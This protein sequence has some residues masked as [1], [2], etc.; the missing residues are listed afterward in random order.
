MS[1]L[2]A[3]PGFSFAEPYAFGVVFVGLAV[4][5]AVAALS[6]QHERAFSA[7]LIYLALGALGA[8]LLSVAG[9][10]WLHPVDNPL[11]LERLTEFAVVF[12]LFG[13]GLSLD[14]RLS[15]REWQTP[16]RLLLVAMPLTIVAV[17]LF[18]TQ[19]MGLSLAAAVLL[20][21]A[22]APTDPVLAG[23]VG[24][25]PP[26]E[27]EEFEP[28]FSLTSEAGLNDGL[29][30]PF[31]LFGV[32]LAKDQANSRWLEWLAAD[33]FYALIGGVLIGWII[34]RAAA[35]SVQGLRDRELLSPGLDGY[36]AIAI[37]LIIYGLGEVAGVYGFLAVFVGGLAFRRYER[38]HEM[39]A[40]VHLGAEQAEKL[41]ELTCVLMLGSMLTL[42]G[43][44]VPGWKGWLLAVVLIVA[45]RP[46][47][48]LVALIGSKLERP[49]ER[50]FVSWFGVRGIGT[51]YYVAFMVAAG[52]LEPGEQRVVAWTAVACV[53]L[54]I[55]VHGITAG[56][57]LGRLLASERARAE[58][59]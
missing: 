16:A 42:P 38:G 57:S 43:L 53:M 45:I 10:E 11:F 3:A 55:V 32:L 33:V 30:F 48:C 34:G 17:A 59:A 51:L 24:V 14:R 12:A 56:P 5:A 13:T 44:L 4:M 47:S 31:V 23:D 7:S 41:T 1:P 27:E 8:V 2:A 28:N 40:N 21:A 39:H 6:H 18:A 25:G 29:A 50:A 35:A 9:I 19:I 22:L 54:S 46:V 36:H 26:G 52:A 37:A 49:G 15:W 20:G 58:A